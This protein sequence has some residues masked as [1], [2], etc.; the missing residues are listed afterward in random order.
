MPV[1]GWKGEQEGCAARLQRRLARA[2][3]RVPESGTY[4]GGHN[5]LTYRP[6][7][8]GRTALFSLTEPRGPRFPTGNP[9]RAGRLQ[10]VCRCCCT[11]SRTIDQQQANTRPR[12]CSV[13]ASNKA[14]PKAGTGTEYS[15]VQQGDGRQLVAP[16]DGADPVAGE[17]SVPRSVRMRG[18]LPRPLEQLPSPGWLSLQVPGKVFRAGCA[19]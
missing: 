2:L 6:T 12:I 4:P 17:P 5:H 13:A 3:P 16:A 8:A 14:A 15:D 18:Q 19:A 7:K 11:V 10:H 9:G 1:K